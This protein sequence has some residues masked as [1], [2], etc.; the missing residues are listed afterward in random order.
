MGNYVF[1][2][3]F[4]FDSL[5]QDADNP[6][7]SRDFGKHHP[8]LIGKHRILATHFETASASPP[9]GATWGRSTHS[10]AQTSNSRKLN[11]NST[12]M[13]ALGRTS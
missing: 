8:K 7:S 1:N 9:T 4:L 5:F 13:T 10:G 3:P 2:T 6:G 12:S 11:P